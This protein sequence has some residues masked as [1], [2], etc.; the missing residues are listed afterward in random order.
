MIGGEAMRMCQL[1]R[2]RAAELV[3]DPLAGGAADDGVVDQGD[4]LALEDVAHRIEL[5]PVA[6]ARAAAADGWMKVRV[7]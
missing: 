2:P 6:P 7:M 1:G 4:T 5:Q 3:D